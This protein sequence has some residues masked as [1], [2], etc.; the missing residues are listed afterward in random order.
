MSQ[1]TSE[2]Y[3]I[4]LEE[5]IINLSLKLK[6]KTNEL[7]LVCE[8]NKKTIGK[9]V[10]NLKNPIGIIYSFSD[11]ML[12]SIEDYTPD[13]LEKYLKI[14]NSSSDFSIKL[15]NAVAKYSQLQIQNTELTCK[16]LNYKDLL[17]D[18]LSEFDSIAIEKNSTI[19]RYFPDEQVFIKADKEEL[20][21]ALNNIINNAFRYSN[22]NAVISISVKLNEN[23]IETTISDDGIG[24]SK[25]NL[26]KVLTNFFVVN[27]YS[28]DKQKCIGLGLAISNKIIQNHNGKL[29][30][31]SEVDKGTQAVIT[32]QK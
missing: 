14:I 10:H 11:M 4:E 26:P 3:I 6:T 8:E 24:I 20:S 27:T 22:E 9:L 1:V 15:L 31:L 23:F 19:K 29:T 25:E 30:L 28:S 16:S 18:I 7:D 13:K 32:L 21:I 17:N 5:R 2:K 12:D